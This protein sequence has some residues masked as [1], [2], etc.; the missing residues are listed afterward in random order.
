MADIN[1]IDLT[2]VQDTLQGTF[3]MH[4]QLTTMADG[5]SLAL[6]AGRTE[7][8][9]SYLYRVE[10][11]NVT[12]TDSGAAEGTVY[13]Y[14]ND[15]GDGTASATVSDTA[16]TYSGTK[17]G[18]YSGTAKAIYV[19]TKSGSSY[20]NR[21]RLNQIPQTELPG[22]INIYNDLTIGG[23][24]SGTSS[25]ALRLGYYNTEGI[26]SPLLES[27]LFSALETLLNNPS[28][29]DYFPLSGTIYH[30]GTDRLYIVSNAR[31]SSSTT[32]SF[33][34]F[35]IS[36][37]QT[38]FTIPDSP[39]SK[40]IWHIKGVSQP[41]STGSLSISSTGTDLLYWNLSA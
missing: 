20:N 21:M 35:S 12:V 15:D 32:Y 4:F 2:D 5:G 11:G 38:E 18:F 40:T 36:Y 1:K 24:F 34:G 6:S 39:Y 26:V 41:I 22:D 23:A 14:I 10:G 13:V 8:V 7:E 31:K 27:N 28:V 17:G 16:P 19:M 37:E 33:R 3:Q 9:G 29:N 25:D 30:R